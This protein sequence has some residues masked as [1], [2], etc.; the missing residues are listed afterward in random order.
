MPSSTSFAGWGRST[1]ND[2]PWGSPIIKVSVDGIAAT[3]SVGSLTVIAKANVSP[4]GTV[5]GATGEV[6]PDLS[7][8]VVAEANSPVTGL[9][10][11]GSV[12]GVTVVAKANVSPDG[13]A[14]TGA[15]APDLSDTV[16]AKA[17]VSPSGT[18][19]GATGQAGEISSVQANAD[20]SVTGVSATTTV[21]SIT[22]WGTIVPDQNPSY[23]PVTPSST[24]AWS[25]VSPSQTPGWDDIAA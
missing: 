6:A 21:G 3:G 9:S 22:V 24:P 10:A 5:P 18:V 25:D 14:A 15:V 17:N 16:I 2:G 8:T 12:G 11:S 7:V 1:W 19:P 13:V 23:T 4:D 20:V